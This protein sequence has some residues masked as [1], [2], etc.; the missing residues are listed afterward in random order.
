MGAGWQ[1][2]SPHR[3][4]WGGSAPSAVNAVKLSTDSTR[5]P[6]GD[7]SR[8]F[9]VAVAVARQSERGEPPVR[10]EYVTCTHTVRSEVSVTTAFTSR[11]HVFPRPGTSASTLSERRSSASRAAVTLIGANVCHRSDSVG[12]VGAVAAPSEPA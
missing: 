5:W 12:V 1:P 8:T 4:R 7:G 9:A 11:T 3:R 10:A 2:S 6:S